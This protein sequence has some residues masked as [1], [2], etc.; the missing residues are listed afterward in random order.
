M[1]L[2]GKQT[3]YFV[4]SQMMRKDSYRLDGSVTGDGIP[5]TNMTGLWIWYCGV[6]FTTGPKR[7]IN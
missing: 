6:C 5:M 1:T 3:N 4:D 2:P 7:R